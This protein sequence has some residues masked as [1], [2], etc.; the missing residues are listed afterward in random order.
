MTSYEKSYIQNTYMSS[1]IIGAVFIPIFIENRHMWKLDM[2][3]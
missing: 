3:F 1:V 2:S